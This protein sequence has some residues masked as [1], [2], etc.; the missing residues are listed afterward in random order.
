MLVVLNVCNLILL[1]TFLL[2]FR[3][4]RSLIT[5]NVKDI[6]RGAVLPLGSVIKESDI[7]HRIDATSDEPSK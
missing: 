1:T 4:R 7:Q 2:V 5:Q 3:K 6:M